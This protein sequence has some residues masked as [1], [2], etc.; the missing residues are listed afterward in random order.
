MLTDRDCKLI[1]QYLCDALK[2][3]TDLQ[4]ILAK[5]MVRTAKPKPRLVKAREAA[6]MLSISDSYLH[7]IKD[8]S[9][10]KPRFSYIKTGPGRTSPLLFDANKIVSE[11]ESYIA[12][13]KVGSPP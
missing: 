3:D 12:S 10:G 2:N 8:D 5:A 11:F 1:V 13:R 9:R 6:R 7:H 4:D